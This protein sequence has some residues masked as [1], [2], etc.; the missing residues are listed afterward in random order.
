MTHSGGK[1][2]ST[3]DRGQRYEIQL[4]PLPGMLNTRTM[5]LVERLT[6][7]ENMMQSALLWP[8]IGA[9]RIYDRKPNGAMIKVSE[10][11]RIDEEAAP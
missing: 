1:A 9:A 4:K 2:H 8:I 5:G 6:A 11:L 3:G 7:A 10:A